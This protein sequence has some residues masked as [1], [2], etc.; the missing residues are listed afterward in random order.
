MRVAYVQFAPVFGKVTQ[1]I[2]QAIALAEATPAD[3]YVFPELFS[4]GYLF[5]DRAEL[6][7]YAEPALGGFTVGHLA[8]WCKRRGVHVCAGFAEVD[9]DNLYNSAAL[10]GPKG[11]M[12][13]YR[14]SHLF[15]REK[16]LFDQSGEDMWEVYECAGA[17]VGMMICFDWI[18]PEA[19]RILALR[20][21]QVILHPANLVLPYCPAAMVTRCVENRVF[22]VTANRVGTEDRPP[23]PLTF[24]GQ[25]RIISPTGEVLAR[26]ADEETVGVADINPAAADDKHITP[27]NDLFSDRRV[28]LYTDLLK[29]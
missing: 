16:E 13:L 12:G 24:I 23:K 28:G 15:W 3:L 20:G 9:G 8:V 14:K 4:T 10:V 21:A 25:S 2:G 11:L 26:A 27:H 29:P 7:T 17:R 1:N 18:F 5:E 22:A 6:K 19:A